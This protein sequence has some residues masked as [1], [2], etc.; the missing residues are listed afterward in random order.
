MKSPLTLALGAAVLALC[1]GAAAAEKS[2]PAL[3]KELS[4]YKSWK[5]VTP[6][7]LRLPDPTA[8]LCAMP[9]PA[10][11]NPHRQFWFNV[12]VNKPGEAAMSRAKSPTFPVGSVIVK[13][14]LKAATAKAPS[15]RTIMIKREEGFDPKAGDWEYLVIGEKGEVTR[16]RIG[17]GEPVFAHCRSCHEKVKDSDYV[18]RTYLPKPRSKKPA[19]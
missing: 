5:R 17:T 19:A 18:F 10:S 11:I 9:A 7:P 3:P 6:K 16:D 12:F 4:A 1:W 15:L 14:K 13:E 2:A 8:A